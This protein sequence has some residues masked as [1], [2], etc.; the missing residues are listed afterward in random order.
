MYSEYLLLGKA[1]ADG[2]WVGPCFRAKIDSFDGNLMLLGGSIP[3][4]LSSLMFRSKP[5]NI[6]QNAI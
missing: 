4:L 3:S 1:E 2:G 6:N 5:S